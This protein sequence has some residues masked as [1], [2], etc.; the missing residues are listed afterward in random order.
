MP[1]FRYDDI[2][3]TRIELES[4]KGTLKANVI[5]SDEGWLGHTLRVFRLTSGGFTPR[6]QH[7][8]EHVNFVLHGRGRLRIGDE[9]FELKEKDF[10]FVPPNTLHQF[11]NPYNDDFEFVCIVPDRG[12]Y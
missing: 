12:A 2:K 1:I 5:G 8:W 6:H 3:L 7:D 11:E 4:V 9:S 10:A